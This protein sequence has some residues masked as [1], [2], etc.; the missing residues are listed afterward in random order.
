[1]QALNP[2]SKSGINI[3]AALSC[4]RIGISIINRFQNIPNI[5]QP[6]R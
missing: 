3:S 4:K 1:M 6:I 2:A 5:P